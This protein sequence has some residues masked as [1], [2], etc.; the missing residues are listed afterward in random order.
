MRQLSLLLLVLLGLT[1]SAKAQ[2]RPMP[3]AA[4]VRKLA[5]LAQ[6]QCLASTV[7]LQEASKANNYSGRVSGLMLQLLPPATYCSCL[8]GRIADTRPMTLNDLDI[9]GVRSLVGEHEAACLSELW[10]E[11]FGRFCVNLGAEMKREFSD[12]LNV[13]T[14]RSEE[15]CSCTGKTVAAFTDR[16]MSRF[17]AESSRQVQSLL[18]TPYAAL[19]P[20]LASL[21]GVFAIC[22]ATSMADAFGLSKR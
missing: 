17:V 1:L 19:E 11:G 10:R 18:A 5:D 12:R 13:N 2:Q 7:P 14:M 22:G 8:Q 20:S 15:V 4:D 3:T 6:T 9:A 16:Q 21:S